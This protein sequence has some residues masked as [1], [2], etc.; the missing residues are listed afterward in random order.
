[1]NKK[2]GLFLDDERN[3]EDVT[4]IT[5]PDNIEWYCLTRMNDF[6]FCIMESDDVDY[7]SFDHDLQDFDLYGGENT[8]YDCL[9][10]LLNYCIDNNKNIPMCFFHSQ[11]VVGKENM[12]SYYNNFIKFIEGE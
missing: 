10:W 12:Q 1:M 2:I 9:K 7:I 4:W 11:N 8:G 6:M 3:P 5:Y